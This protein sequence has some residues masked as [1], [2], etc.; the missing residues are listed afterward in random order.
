MQQTI[1]KESKIREA[2]KTLFE[3]NGIASDVIKVNSVVDTS[4]IVTDPSNIDYKPNSKAEFQ[5]AITTIIDDLSDEEIPNVYNIVKNTLEKRTEEEGKKKMNKKS[6][7]TEGT[8]RLIIR[9]MLVEA[10]DDEVDNSSIPKLPAIK[11]IPA[12]VHG[13]EYLSK[14][15]NAIKGLQSTFKNMRDDVDSEEMDRQDKP[16]PG[17]TRRNKMDAAEGLKQ[18]AL[19]LGFKNPNGALQFL[20]KTLEKMKV[21][22]ENYDDVMVSSLEAMND[23]IAKLSQAGSF[24]PAD[25]QLLKDH[26]EIVVDLDSF[27]IYL[28]KMLKKKGL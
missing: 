16:A 12:G 22:I 6:V 20:N 13:A 10:F 25:V 19:E 4:A 9:K 24:T 17:R 14:R 5:V 18:M 7:T 8:I 3:N 23:Y 26:P 1:F 2:I 28:N 11:K 15:N 27:R 21:R